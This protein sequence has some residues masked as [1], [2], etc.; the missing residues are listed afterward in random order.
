MLSGNC[1]LGALICSVILFVILKI[2]VIFNSYSMWC[3]S[4]D[5]VLYN[6]G[7]KHQIFLQYIGAIMVVS[8]WGRFIPYYES[9][10]AQEKEIAF[11]LN[12]YLLN[13]LTQ[14]LPIC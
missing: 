1:R 4:A 12:H 9:L 6:C 13:K 3:T 2:T 7:Q 5:E 11:S 14:T 8:N 10:L